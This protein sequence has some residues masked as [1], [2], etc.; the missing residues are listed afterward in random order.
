[1]QVQAKGNALVMASLRE[2]VKRAT[3]HFA[4]NAINA[5]R[6]R[7]APPPLEAIKLHPYRLMRDTSNA[8]RMTLVLPSLSSDMV[9]GGV[10]T[11]MEIFLH[12]AASAGAQP[13][14]AIDDFD[15]RVDESFLARAA[16]RAGLAVG[17]IEVMHRDAHQQSILVRANEVFFAFNWWTALNL[18]PL[19]GEQQAQFDIGQRPLIQVIQDYEPLFYP[20][21]STHLYARSAL[22]DARNWAIV[23]SSQL[24]MYMKTQGHSFEREYVFEPRLSSGLRPFLPDEPVAKEKTILVYGRPAVPRNCF[25]AVV[26]GLRLFVRAHPEF[27]NWTILSAGSAHSPVALGEGKSLRPLGKLSLEEYGARLR[28]AGV[29]LSLMASPHPSYPP[30][31]MAHFGILTITNAYACKDLSRAHDNI[32][33]LGDISPPTIAEA[34][35]RACRIVEDDPAAGWRGRSHVPAYLETNP[36]DIYDR[37]GPDLNGLFLS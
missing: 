19:L 34:L 32:S 22:N 30:L 33:S 36:L 14:I 20:M 2:T 3:P 31:E 29:G 21:S 37:L 11:G 10:S 8:R 9:F 18:A 27:R 17:D 6:A 24:H 7:L 26:D 13:R 23:N 1:M 12:C 5:V 35:A 4:R 25:S 28:N 16:K 15:R